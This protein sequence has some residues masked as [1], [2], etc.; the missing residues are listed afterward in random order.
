MR[1]KIDKGIMQF[2]ITRMSQEG[3]IRQQKFAEQYRETKAS[4]TIE[5]TDQLSTPIN[6][7]ISNL[8]FKKET[9][10][11]GADDH[12]KRTIRLRIAKQRKNLNSSYMSEIDR[13]VHRANRNDRLKGLSMLTGGT[14]WLAAINGAFSTAPSIETHINQTTQEISTKFM[15]PSASEILEAESR[16]LSNQ[17]GEHQCTIDERQA[18]EVLLQRNDEINN[19]IS[20]NVKK[21]KADHEK[22]EATWKILRYLGDIGGAFVLLFGYFY[23]KVDNSYGFGT[24]GSWKSDRSRRTRAVEWEPVPGTE[25]LDTEYQ[26]PS[27]YKQ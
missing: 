23:M 13:N 18:D 8:P 24:Y 1:E 16:Q 21:I 4:S 14:L 10:A 5:L 19:I 2:R 25:G 12:Y 7:E 27:P 15:Q 9:S 20:D 17:C 6:E 11:R 22:S 3:K 26:P